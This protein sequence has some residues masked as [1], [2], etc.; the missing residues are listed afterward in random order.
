MM[1]KVDVSAV[2]HDI[3]QLVENFL[4]MPILHKLPRLVTL[5]LED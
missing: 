3:E 1:P 2:A 4:A 5:V